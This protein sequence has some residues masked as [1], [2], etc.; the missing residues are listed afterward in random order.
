[1]SVPQFAYT[2]PNDLITRKTKLMILDFNVMRYHSFDLFRYLLLDHEY[3]I[4]IDPSMVPM[5]KDQL[6]IAELIDFYRNNSL[7]LNPFD[8][9]THT[10]DRIS[11]VELDYHTRR[12]CAD[13]KA[14]ITETQLGYNLYPVICANSVDTTYV[15]YRDDPF[16]PEF[17]NYSN[18]KVI[19]VDQIFHPPGIA[20]YIMENTINAIMIGSVDLAILIAKELIVN[21]YHEPITI[22]VCNY[23][24]NFQDQ[25][26]PMLDNKTIR[27]MNH[28]AEIVY[29]TDRYQY[30]FC[31]IDPYTGLSY[32]K[33]LLSE[34]E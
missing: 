30:E 3:F 33:Q 15:H 4:H 26:I 10:A 34:D 5:V 28:S 32:A 25:P 22:M 11:A 14:I 9:F 20:K 8:Q 19:G 29:L 2:A 13:S 18:V 6:P 21:Q 1:M 12:M 24:Y 31:A 27:V 16:T 23:R 17:V 7:T